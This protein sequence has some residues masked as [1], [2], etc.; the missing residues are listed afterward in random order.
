MTL[1]KILTHVY[2]QFRNKSVSLEGETVENRISEQHE[3]FT[4]LTPF[5][6]PLVIVGGKYDMFQ[7]FEP[8]KR[9]L[10]C[11]SLRQVAHSMAAS[12]IFYSDKDAGLV[13]R[14]RDVFNYHGFGGSQW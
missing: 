10:I 14:L 8:E 2:M 13:K 3:D 1:E 11:R 5:P 4:F 6:T 9:K 7:E 12:L